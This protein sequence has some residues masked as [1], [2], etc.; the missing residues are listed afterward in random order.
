MSQG[1][2]FDVTSG[3]K[4]LYEVKMAG[5][6]FRVFS[7]QNEKMVDE[8][9]SL[10]DQRVGEILKEKKGASFEKA[11]CL[12]SL[13]FAEELCVLKQKSLDRLQRIED[14]VDDILTDIEPSSSTV[15]LG[16]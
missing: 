8:L 6:P 9:V 14:Q 3:E 2:G 7:S 11:I 5:L 16:K 15:D 4:K 10:V 1:R 13:N 12:V